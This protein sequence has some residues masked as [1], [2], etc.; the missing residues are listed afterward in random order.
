M[1]FIIVV[2]QLGTGSYDCVG[3]IGAGVR[4]RDE[5]AIAGG[6]INGNAGQDERYTSNISI[7]RT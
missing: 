3:G 7:K 4:R 1:P 5:E 2:P 6:N